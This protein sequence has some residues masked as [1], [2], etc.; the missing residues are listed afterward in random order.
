MATGCQTPIAANSAPRKKISSAMP[1]TRVMTA[2]RGSEPYRAKASTSRHLPQRRDLP[3]HDRADDEQRGHRQPE[4]DRHDDGPRSS[5][6]YWIRPRCSGPEA[7]PPTTQVAAS[8]KVS[9]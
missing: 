6:L 9:T 4:Q 3:D 7:K 5:P 1:L 8:A 2:T